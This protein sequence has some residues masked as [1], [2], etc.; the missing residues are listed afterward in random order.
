MSL[1]IVGMETNKVRAQQ[2]FQNFFAPRQ[3][4]EYLERGEG[5]MQKEANSG[6]GTFF[7]H[8]LRYQHQLVIMYPNGI[9]FVG[10]LDDGIGKF[11]VYRFVGVPIVQFK[12]GILQKIMEQGPNGPITETVVKTINFIG[13]ELYLG[14]TVLFQCYSNIIFELFGGILVR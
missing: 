4:S 11:L 13:I 8:H 3:G 12:F 14:A 9:I 5:N 7:T 1:I 10:I 2:S 6:I